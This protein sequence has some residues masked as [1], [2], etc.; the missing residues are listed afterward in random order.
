[1]CAVPP[2]ATALRTPSPT[3]SLPTAACFACAARPYKA[4]YP[5]IASSLHGRRGVVLSHTRPSSPSEI[6]GSTGHRDAS[7][8]VQSSHVVL[9]LHVERELA[10][11]SVHTAKLRL[12]DLA[13]SDSIEKDS[14]LAALG[15]VL[16]AMADGKAHL[17]CRDST[18]TK[19]LVAP[20]CSQA[21]LLACVRS[22]A[23]EHAESLA[24]LQFAQAA[25]RGRG[26]G[27]G[28]SGGTGNSGGGHHGLDPSADGLNLIGAG[29]KQRVASVPMR[30]PPA[31]PSR[32]ESNGKLDSGDQRLNR[33]HT[34]QILAGTEAY[35]EVQV[36]SAPRRSRQWSSPAPLPSA[37]TFRVGV[38]C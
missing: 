18:L 21:A 8:L 13:T 31:P 9:V 36:A 5:H 10:D 4:Q 14:G 20:L 15:A 38:S 22:S 3:C 26:G 29:S 28:G 37:A 6:G 33:H 2:T 27:G 17:P 19:L 16:A 34:L 11:G 7:E 24:T 23:S 25:M 32:L 30:L 1:M 12:V 35:V